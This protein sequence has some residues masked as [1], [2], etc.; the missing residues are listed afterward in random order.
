MSIF[1]PVDNLGQI[2]DET[3]EFS[4]SDHYNE[5]K[6][7]QDGAKPKLWWLMLMVIFAAMSFMIRLAVLQISQGANNQLLAE[8]NRIR[9]R[10]I[11]PPRGLIIDRNSEIIAKNIASFSATI[12][13]A[14]LPRDNDLRAGVYQ[15]LQ[16][17]YGRELTDSLRNTIEEQ[18]LRSLE[19]I[20]ISDYLVHEEALKLKIVFED[21]P[22][23]EI[24]Q[25]PRREYTE[26]PG[27]AHILGF[28]GKISQEELEQSKQY[29]LQSITGK[30]GIEKTYEA[31]LQG[32]AGVEQ[33]EVDSRGY[34]QRIVGNQPPV[35]GDTIMLSIDLGMQ[36][37][38]GEAI[39]KKLEEVKSCCGVGIALN[40]QNSEVLAMVS[41]PDFPSNEFTGGISQNRYQE[42]LNDSNRPFTNRA[43][44]GTYPPGSTIKPSIAIAGLAEGVINEQTKINAPGEIRIGEFVFPDWKVH[45]LVDVKKA[46]AV[47]S[48]VFFYAVGGGWASITGLGVDRIDKYLNLLGFGKKTGIDLGGE[49]EGLVP[50]AEWKKQTKGEPW[51]QGDTYHLSIGQGDLLITPMQLLQAMSIIANR[52]QTHVP[53][54]LLKSQKAQANS[55]NQQG[56]NTH[57]AGKTEVK[58]NDDIFRIVREGMKQAVESGSARRLQQLS[59]SAGGKTGT[60][61]FGTEDKTHAWFT[62]FAPYDNPEIAILVLIE[63]GG[64]GHEAALPVA[65]ETLKWYFAKKNNT[66]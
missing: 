54:L 52:G 1:G 37:V 41:L 28:T 27:I 26:A 53:H 63:G 51:Y 64:A 5:T 22:G 35:S 32:V 59:V 12:I 3:E 17:V 20:V 29:S 56:E 19:P 13:P 48:N 49:Q 42:L 18:G 46:I 14:D 40:P 21:S 8:G 57:R 38:L 45:G 39:K 65:L 4:L 15:K 31:L 47:S 2:N 61:Q 6:L 30:S 60:A 43:V 10:E 25:K 33:V 9:T 55:A 36:K 16:E 34:F 11:R 44:A 23:I 58:L 66:N 7:E 62:A 50:T 24:A